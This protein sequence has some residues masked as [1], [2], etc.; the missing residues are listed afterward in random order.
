MKQ[1]IVITGAT[2]NVGHE[3]AVRLLAR[4]IPVRAIAR[5][6]DKLA[7]LAARGAEVRPASI[8]DAAAMETAFEGATAA[9]AMIPPNRS[10]EDQDGFATSIA[11]NVAAGLRAAGVPRVVTLSSCGIDVGLERNHRLFEEVFDAVEG[12]HRV[13]LRPGLFMEAY[14]RQIPLIKK[15]GVNRGFWNPNLPL[16][17]VAARDIGAVGAEHLATS[18]F[19]GRKLHYVLGPRDLTMTEATR[20]LGRSVGIDNLEYV[21]E[22]PDDVRTRML[23][24]GFSTNYIDHYIETRNA[25]ND[26]GA[27]S[28]QPRSPENTT[29]TTLEHYAE[30]VFAPAYAAAG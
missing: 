6:A 29:P 22:T 9:F 20:I 11:R 7:E 8:E 1:L 16:S 18:D 30:T 24:A 26:A 13:H 3:I 21:L 2:G 12:L 4:G 17:T 25:Y 19:E 10:N 27:V 28:R 15:T 14:L 23:K 5:T